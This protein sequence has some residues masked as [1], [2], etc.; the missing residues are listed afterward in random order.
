MKK[1][2]KYNIL[3]DSI[4]SLI[5]KIAIPA[6]IGGVFTTLYNVID[7]IFA[8]QIGNLGEGLAGVSITF[9]LYLLIFS[10]AAG[11]GTG[12]VAILGNLIGEGKE[13]EGRR[14]GYNAIYLS[15]IISIIFLG[16][17]YPLIIPILKF[18]KTTDSV[19]PY[20]QSYIRV[21]YLG[22]LTFTMARAAN[23]ILIAQGETKPYK[24]VLIFGFF[25]NIILDPLFLQ[26][27]PLYY[28]ELIWVKFG[29]FISFGHLGLVTHIDKVVDWLPNYGTAGIAIATILIQLIQTIYVVF[30]VSRTELFKGK[31]KKEEMK[32][33]FCIMRELLKQ[34]LPSTLNMVATTVGV[35]LLNYFV[36]FIGGSHGVA[37][38]GIGYRIEQ[39]IMLL[40][41][42]IYTAMLTMIAQNRGA[43]N[44]K[45]IMEIFN[46]G[47]ALS[48]SLLALG[49]ILIYFLK[50]SLIGLFTSD[51]EI[52]R[53][54]VE[55][56]NI[57]LFTVPAYAIISCGVV[58]YQG[59]KKPK[60]P[61]YVTIVRQFI[62]P[63][64]FY[65]LITFV[66]KLPLR[67]IWMSVFLSAW[68]MGLVLIFKAR[69]ELKKVYI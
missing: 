9:P 62:F 51:S 65:N 36:S 10:I 20:A 2:K 15:I 56:L 40:A 38:L 45:R 53:I 60:I 46:K 58:T 32:I 55:Y 31:L 67:F 64:I 43:Q 13:K 8:G 29:N 66:F 28:L 63:M 42:G 52:I 4:F 50:Y 35:F 25:L 57:E 1:I 39:I 37:A 49:S 7:T 27:N 14:T 33:D 24:N 30:K 12:T 69:K 47:I 26:Q 5:R 21:I 41:G 54:T 61:M 34:G 48:V 18:L 68:S 59:I 44:N 6:S 11:L 19:L 22:I 16:L 23:A 3:E 17:F